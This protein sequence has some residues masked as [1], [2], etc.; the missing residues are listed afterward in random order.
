M[1]IF[2]LQL[3]KIKRL[4][5]LNKCFLISLKILEYDIFSKLLLLKFV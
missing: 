5:I 1:F 4:F 2:F 3:K